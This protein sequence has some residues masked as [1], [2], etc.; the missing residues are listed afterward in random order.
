VFPGGAEPLAREPRRSP[1][2][3]KPAKEVIDVLLARDVAARLKQNPPDQWPEKDEIGKRLIALVDSVEHRESLSPAIKVAE[4]IERNQSTIQDAAGSAAG[5]IYRSTSPEAV[6]V[7]HA[8]RRLANGLQR[9]PTR[10]ELREAVKWQ[11]AIKEFTAL[12]R[13]IG[14]AWLQEDHAARKRRARQMR[15][16]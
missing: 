2:N 8:C 13:E 1:G 15:T 4:S 11:G 5:K 9:P 6:C 7:L 16:S 3:G 12:L 10:K 14:L